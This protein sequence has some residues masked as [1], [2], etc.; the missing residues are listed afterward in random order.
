MSPLIFPT[1]RAETTILQALA[2]EPGLEK[3]KCTISGA[4]E[5]HKPC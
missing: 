1:E 4:L 3:Q 5:L 2:E